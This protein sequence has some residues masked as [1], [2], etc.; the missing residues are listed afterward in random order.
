MKD[1]VAS[2]GFVTDLIPLI[3]DRTKKLTYRYGSKY[4][5]VQV[6][7]ARTMISFEN[8]VGKDINKNILVIGASGSGKTHLVEKLKGQYPFLYDADTI[9]GLA[10]WI[11]WEK[12]PVP[13]PPDADKEWLDTHEFLW[14]REALQSFIKEHEHIV[15]FGLSGNVLDMV[16]LFDR[17]YYLDAAPDTIR[18]RLKKPERSKLMGKTPEQAERVIAYMQEIGEKAKTMDIPFIKAE[19]TPEQI[20]KEILQDE[21]FV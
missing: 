20:L 8:M 12:K 4:N 7:L 13:F 11:D 14:D 15:I 5:P 6:W 17:V 3:L 19:Q 2:I 10:S 1:E 21:R 16:D 18:E 9:S